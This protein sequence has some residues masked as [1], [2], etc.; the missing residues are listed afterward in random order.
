M[1]NILRILF[2]GDDEIV[3]AAKVADDKDYSISWN[4]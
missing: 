4:Q 2:L 1:S 3:A